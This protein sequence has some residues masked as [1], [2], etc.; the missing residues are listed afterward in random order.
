MC[1]SS[2]GLTWLTVYVREDSAASI[3]SRAFCRIS[4]R[5]FF[6]SAL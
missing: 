3:M 2:S 1:V 6:C 5:A 4:S